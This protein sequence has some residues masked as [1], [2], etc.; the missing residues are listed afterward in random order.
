MI[1]KIRCETL[2]TSDSVSILRFRWRV[3]AVASEWVNFTHRFNNTR[4]AEISDFD[5]AIGATHQDICW[6]YVT[7][8][9]V[10]GHGGENWGKFIFL[11]CSTLFSDL[12]LYFVLS[13]LFM[14]F[15]VFCFLINFVCSCVHMEHVDKK[16]KIR[17]LKTVSS[18]K[19]IMRQ[20][21][22]PLYPK[23]GYT[24]DVSSNVEKRWSLYYSHICQFFSRFTYSIFLLTGESHLK[25]GDIS[26]LKE[27]GKVCTVRVPWS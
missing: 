15:F 12:L 3:V 22:K 6:F 5:G 24:A 16:F 4:K 14:F 8:K 27:V 2:R 9:K 7:N 17:N 25:N 19:T 1:Q 11:A 13:Y 26:P 23:W 21:W 10:V 20:I 18:N